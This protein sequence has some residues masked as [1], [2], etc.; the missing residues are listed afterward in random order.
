MSSSVPP[1]GHPPTDY[2]GLYDAPEPNA[3]EADP[4]SLGSAEDDTEETTDPG[5]EAPVPEALRKAPPP[6][7]YA[8][9]YDSPDAEEGQA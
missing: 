9:F 7:E 6:A 2:E 8:D 5:S 1:T 4:A 3:S